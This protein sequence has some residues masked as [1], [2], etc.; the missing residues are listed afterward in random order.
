LCGA[1]LAWTPQNKTVAGVVKLPEGIK[2]ENQALEWNKSLIIPIR[3]S[4]EI[5]IP[6]YSTN[7]MTTRL[8]IVNS[9]LKVTA[10]I[11]IRKILPYGILNMPVRIR[12]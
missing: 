2:T 3:L 7:K 4:S 9:R 12:T 5:Q 1:W 8:N 11:K 10:L 6:E